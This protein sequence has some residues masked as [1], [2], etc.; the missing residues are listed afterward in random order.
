MTS[1]E[2]RDY[3]IVLARDTVTARTYEFVSGPRAEHGVDTGELLGGAR[4]ANVLLELH[5][6]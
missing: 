2:E 4:H 5:E 3:L 6:A 1:V